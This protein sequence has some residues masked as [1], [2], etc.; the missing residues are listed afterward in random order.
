MTYEPPPGTITTV[1]TARPKPS[2]CRHCG[3]NPH[4]GD[5]CYQHIPGGLFG[6][7]CPCFVHASGRPGPRALERLAEL[8]VSR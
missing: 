7:R 4:T 8:G 3:H 1:V 2:P 6:L 5:L